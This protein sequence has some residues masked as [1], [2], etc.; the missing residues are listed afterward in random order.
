VSGYPCQ[1]PYPSL[2]VLQP[3]AREPSFLRRDPSSSKGASVN[4]F[5][6]NF[7]EAPG[8]E[9]QPHYTILQAISCSWWEEEGLQAYASF[10]I[11]L[12]KVRPPASAKK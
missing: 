7:D 9:T 8:L 6:I 4:V 5:L 11:D 3:T 1:R 10:V 2:T 12:V